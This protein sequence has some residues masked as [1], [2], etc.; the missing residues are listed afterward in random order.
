MSRLENIRIKIKNAKTN[1]IDKICYFFSKDYTA[2]ET[3]KELNISRQTINH[4]Y[5][6]FR[7]NLLKE[8]NTI[9][10]SS[11][12]KILESSYL[13][14]R[15]IKIQKEDLFFIDY[16][17]DLF[18][19]DETSKDDCLLF[20]F[21]HS[22]LANQLKNH[23][24]A[25]SAR[26]ILNSKKDGF[27]VSG[28][29]KKEDDFKLYCENRLKKFRGI[30]RKKFFDYLTESQIRFIYSSDLIYQKIVLSFK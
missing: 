20:N 10:C 6:I 4:Y 15:Y 28:F 13:N 14:I 18:L 26:I 30:N 5:K 1:K 17:N 21:L 24:R 23:K 7:E 8:F 27:I 3:A 29:F 16:H 9:G 2:V 22:S 19:L 25:N 12:E 11:F